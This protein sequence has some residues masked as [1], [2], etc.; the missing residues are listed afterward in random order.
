MLSAHTFVPF[1]VQKLPDYNAFQVNAA[2][3]AAAKKGEIFCGTPHPLELSLFFTM[4]HVQMHQP[5][6]ACLRNHVHVLGLVVD[7][8]V[9][10]PNLL[11]QIDTSVCTCDDGSASTLGSCSS[12]HPLAVQQSLALPTCCIEV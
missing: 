11:L 7:A 9:G 3:I 5:L 8:G 2:M 12:K 6:P 10:S 4:C 1:P